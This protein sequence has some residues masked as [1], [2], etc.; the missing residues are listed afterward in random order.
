MNKQLLLRSACI[1]G[2]FFLPGK[3]G[4][5]ES[6][7][8]GDRISFRHEPD[9]QADPMAVRAVADDGV[10]IG[11]LQKEMSPCVLLFLPSYL[12]YGVVSARE[13]NGNVLVDIF[14]E[15]P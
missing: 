3:T 4:T 1:K 5:T 6:V 12:V 15:K 2:Q 14:A 7:Q 8:A 9:N 10:V 13:K 11:Y